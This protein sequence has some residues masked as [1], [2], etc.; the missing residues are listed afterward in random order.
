M[1]IL[2]MCVENSA[3][4][5]LAEGLAKK[6]FGP[7][8]QVESAGSKPSK[9]NPLAIES[10]KEIG[11]DLS[12][13]NSKSTDDLSPDFLDGLDYVITLC[14]EEVCPIV[15]SKAKKLHW[16]LSDPAGHDELSHKEKLELFQRTRD[17]IQEK[18]IKFKAE[19]KL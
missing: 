13:H 7:A 10:M 9:V 2:F 6:I 14:A 19:L 8:A 15:I 4:S 3:R 5:Q 11:I 16:P 18:L 1:K 12:H 17:S